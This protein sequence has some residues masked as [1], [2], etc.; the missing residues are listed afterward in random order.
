MD[1]NFHKAPYL[2]KCL[3]DNMS[4]LI[5][6][7]DLDSRFIM[8]NKALAQWQGNCTPEE[9]IGKSDLDAYT[10]A[11]AER[12]RDNE[13][14]IIKTGEPLLGLEEHETWRNG[15]QAWVSTTKMPLRNDAG[16]I[17][18][19]F[20]ISRDITEHK[21]AELRAT[22]YARQVK[23]YAQEA[24]RIKEE[25]ENDMRLAGELQKTFFPISYPIF[26][27]RATLGNCR[28]SFH[29][30]HHTGGLVGG[31]FCSV[32]KLS[33]THAGI[34]LC[35]VMGHGVRAALGTAIVCAMV[36]EPSNTELDPGRF[37]ERMNHALTPLLHPS[38]DLIY[39]TACYLVLDTST[40]QARMANAGHPSPVCLKADGQVE[41]CITD[42]EQRG[43]ALA[44]LDNVSYPTL[45]QQIHPGDAIVL[46]TDG[47]FEIAGIN[48]EEYGEHRLLESFQR[49]HSL[50]LPDLFPAILKEARLFADENAFDDDV[51]LVG[52][53]FCPPA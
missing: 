1:S 29:H 11:D 7:K 16:E 8:V 10:A 35:D 37:L 43:P 26:P 27:E 31:D 28:I 36:D 17:I 12:M 24:H 15:E 22:R 3:M 4:D 45:E 48:N 51:C 52:V 2:L 34:F 33:E 14:H 23:L 32:R 38:D 5:Y 30:H 46:F 19:I 21:E 6:F 40:G 13:K 20:G 39:A 41:W 53:R 18:G 47:I 25:L 9:L 42:H 44:L 49:N 50:S